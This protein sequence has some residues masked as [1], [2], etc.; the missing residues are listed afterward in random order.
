MKLFRDA[1]EGTDRIRVRTNVR[2]AQ[3]PRRTL[4]EVAHPEEVRRVLFGLAIHET[5][6]F[7]H[8][9]CHG[10]ESLEFYRGATL[11][12][13]LN[14]HHGVTLTWASPGEWPD[15]A[16]LTRESGDFLVRWL[17]DHGVPEPQ[18]QRADARR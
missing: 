16:E 18:K 15:D 9:F 6:R 13:T 11:L 10:T 7:F 8:D 5:Y 12:G 1:V 4:F 17:A 2:R 3:E 14:L